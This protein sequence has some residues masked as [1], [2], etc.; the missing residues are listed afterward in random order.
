M[1]HMNLP[2]VKGIYIRMNIKDSG[3]RRRE[4][5][6]EKVYPK[7]NTILIQDLKPWNDTRSWY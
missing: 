7:G 4:H 3:L 2:S 1:K 5:K 6:V